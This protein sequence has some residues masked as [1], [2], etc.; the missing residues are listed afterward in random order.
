MD[1]PGSDTS[2]SFDKF[3]QPP[4]IEGN[5][6]WV[7]CDIFCAGPGGMQCRS[8]K[9]PRSKRLTH[10]TP[11]AASTGGIDASVTHSVPTGDFDAWCEKCFGC[12]E[13]IEEKW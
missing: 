12:D 2:S 4:I 7:F 11:T 6:K 13:A 10:T 1:G 9:S 5:D 8:K 3:K